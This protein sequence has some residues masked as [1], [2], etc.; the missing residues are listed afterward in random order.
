MKRP[1]NGRR[2]G[3]QCGSEEESKVEKIVRD[4]IKEQ[5]YWL[6]VRQVVRK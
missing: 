6:L 5:Y 4:Y 3:W 1:E 2:S